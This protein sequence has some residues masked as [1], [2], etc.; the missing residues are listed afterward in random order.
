[1]GCDNVSP[2]ILKACA[3]SLCEPIANFFNRIMDCATIPMIWKR[4]MI[5]PV[6]KKGDKTKIVNYRPISLLCIISKVMESII[7][8]SIIDFIRPTLSVSQYGFL[9]GRSSTTQL[10]SCYNRVMEGFDA[11][12]DSDILY[13]DLQKAFDSVA[14]QE[15]LFKLWRI[16]ITGKLWKWFQNYLLDR[17]HY[18]SY[19][20]ATSITPEVRGSTRECFGP[21]VISCLHQRCVCGH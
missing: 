12:Q 14:H 17:Q 16:G 20:G 2:K 21:S 8:S 19:E 13:L 18:V 6:P 4:H 3:A 9:S 1:M 10:L 7:Y 15:L 5:T 11:G